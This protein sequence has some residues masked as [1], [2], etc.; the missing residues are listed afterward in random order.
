M[1][2]LE[3]KILDRLISEG[4]VSHMSME[5]EYDIYKSTH[6]RMTQYKQTLSK[7]TFYSHIVASKQILNS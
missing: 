1:V 4:R 6:K 3:N 7:R 5:E 2:K